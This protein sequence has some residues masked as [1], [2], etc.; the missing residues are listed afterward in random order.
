MQTDGNPS[1]VF[2]ADHQ[3]HVDTETYHGSFLRDQVIERETNYDHFKK[4]TDRQKDRNP[5]SI[6]LGS[7]ETE[8]HQE[9][10]L[11]SG[12]TGTET[13][14]NTR[15]QN[16]HPRLNVTVSSCLLVIW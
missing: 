14:K 16:P 8:T 6:F 10:F 11:R 4:R 1:I 2:L 3:K 9:S 12:Q 15:E 5:P 7:R 13:E